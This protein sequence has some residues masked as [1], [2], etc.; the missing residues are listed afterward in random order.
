MVLSFSAQKIKWYFYAQ[1]HNKPSILRNCIIKMVSLEVYRRVYRLNLEREFAKLASARD[2]T[3]ENKQLIRDYYDWLIKYGDKPQTA[4]QSFRY[5]MRKARGEK[6][7]LAAYTKKDVNAWGDALLHAGVSTGTQCNYVAWIKHFYQFVHQEELI[8][9]YKKKSPKGESPKEIK[10]FPEPDVASE[11]PFIRRDKKSRTIKI[12]QKEKILEVIKKISLPQHKAIFYVLN[13]AGVRAGELLNMKIGDVRPSSQ[14]LTIEITEGKTGSR[15]IVLDQAA[16]PLRQWINLHPFRDD[17]QASLWLN[18]WNN[19]LNHGSLYKLLNNYGIAAGLTKMNP[20]LLRHSACTFL[21]EKE[22][23]SAV[24]QE[25]F[26]WT[27]TSAMPALYTHLTPIAVHRAVNRARGKIVDE[28]SKEDAMTEVICSNCGARNAPDVK[29]CTVCNL[30]PKDRDLAMRLQR[31][32][33]LADVADLL[34]LDDSQ[35]ETLQKKARTMDLDALSQLAATH[36]I[37]VKDAKS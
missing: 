35:R 20:H 15:T 2:I 5:I 9:R 24:M 33:A 22:I 18:K 28:E 30:P 1:P 23:S 11:L 27:D 32:K 26:G 36:G 6:R 31:Q 17:E 3:A 13:E 4:I 19:P 12:P 29:Y 7:S 10:N 25:Y 21:S 37:K 34:G 8:A 16:A 14:G